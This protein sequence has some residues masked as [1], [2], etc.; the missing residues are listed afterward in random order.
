MAHDAQASALVLDE[1]VPI[2]FK[3]RLSK[4]KY[5]QQKFKRKVQN[6]ERESLV[7]VIDQHD[8]ELICNTMRAFNEAR[9]PEYQ[10]WTTYQQL[11]AKFRQCVDGIFRTQYLK[12]KEGRPAIVAGFDETIA[13]FLQHFLQDGA[14]ANQESYLQRITKP[15]SMS[16]QEVADRLSEINELM[17]YFPTADGNPPLSEQKKKNFF[18]KMM[19][20]TWQLDYAGSIDRLDDPNYTFEALVRNMVTRASVYNVRKSNF[21]RG[22]GNGR[23]NGG[24]SN[25]RSYDGNQEQNFNTYRRLN[26]GNR[27]GGRGRSNNQNGRNQS[28]RGNNGGRGYSNGGR[29]NYGNRSSG[30]RGNYNRSNGYNNKGRGGNYYNNQGGGGNFQQQQSYDGNFYNNFPDFPGIIP[31]IQGRND[32]YFQQQQQQQLP[33]FPGPDN[34]RHVRFAGYNG[35]RSQGGNQDA[36]WLDNIMH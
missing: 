8:A 28:G 26:N 19:L 35:G 31:T 13:A 16:C 9:K 7:P 6:E 21:N 20:P 36:H 1:K 33:P 4:E 11:D 24:R 22:R 15:F 18:F 23:G 10:N 25:R 14:L 17:A 3:P 27:D 34:G 29:G 30:G 12:L 32:G 2:I 5:R